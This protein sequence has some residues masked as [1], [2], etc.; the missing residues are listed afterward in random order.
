MCS[1]LSNVASGGCPGAVVD[2]IVDT[3]KIR[4][5]TFQDRF[6]ARREPEV[7]DCRYFS[8]VAQVLFG[9][10]EAYEDWFDLIDDDQATSLTFTRFPACTSRLPARPKWASEF[11]NS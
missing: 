4:S 9:N 11:H 1:W 2:C 10:T 6:A 8:D 5:Q 3:I 7:F